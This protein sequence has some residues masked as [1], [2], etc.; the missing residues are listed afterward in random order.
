M[1]DKGIQ[2]DI[3]TNGLHQSFQQSLPQ[4]L[5]LQATLIWYPREHPLLD[6]V[7]LK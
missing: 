3:H 7:I 1:H 2:Y 4:T 5:I 6:P